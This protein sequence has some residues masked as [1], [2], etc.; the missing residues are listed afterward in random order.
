MVAGCAPGVRTMTR[1]I[2]FHWTTTFGTSVDVPALSWPLFAGEAASKRL[3]S[4]ERQAHASKKLIRSLRICISS[5]R[6]SLRI[7]DEELN[8]ALPDRAPR[9]MD[10]LIEKIFPYA[11]IRNAVSPRAFL[12]QAFTSR[13]RNK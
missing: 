6:F 12:F 11:H 10:P 5:L 1:R 8:Q 13:F 7:T 9:G 4:A 3:T 2:L